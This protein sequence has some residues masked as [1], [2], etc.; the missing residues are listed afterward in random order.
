M[1]YRGH[2]GHVK[3]KTTL[4]QAFTVEPVWKP[5]LIV[6]GFNFRFIVSIQAMITRSDQNSHEFEIVLNIS[7]PESKALDN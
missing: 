6:K 5:Y 7:H 2:T 3:R 1:E 4:P